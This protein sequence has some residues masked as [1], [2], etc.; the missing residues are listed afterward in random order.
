MAAATAAVDLGARHA[1]GAILRLAHRV[2]ERLPEA[3]PAGA[4]LELGVGGK[5][6][7]VAAGAGEDALAM[8][9][10]QRAGAR[11]LGAV[12]AQDV[13]LHRREL[14]APLGV[15]LLNL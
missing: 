14:R 15:G 13:V 8:L 11:P 5:Q 2:V 6:R 7:Q 4:A 3:R 10:Q 12:L 9:L 1:E